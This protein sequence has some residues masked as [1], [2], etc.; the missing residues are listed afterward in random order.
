MSP[1][2]PGFLF[3]VP[4]A[5]I[6]PV[7]IYGCKENLLSIGWDDRLNGHFII[8]DLK[9]TSIYITLSELQREE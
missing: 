7:S 2:M 9:L 4:S 3:L 1:I 8:I 6:I 5:T